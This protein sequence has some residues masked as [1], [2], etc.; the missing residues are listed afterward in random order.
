M[1]SLCGLGAGETG[2][3]VILATAVSIKPCFDPDPGVSGLL[4]VTVRLWQTN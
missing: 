1:T 3:N 2:A 4:P